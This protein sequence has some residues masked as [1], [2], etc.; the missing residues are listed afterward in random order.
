MKSSEGIVRS[1]GR[2]R[3]F[4][5]FLGF[6]DQKNVKIFG[7]DPKRVYCFFQMVSSRYSLKGVSFGSNGPFKMK[8]PYSI[9]V[10]CLDVED[11]REPHLCLCGNSLFFS[12]FFYF[13]NT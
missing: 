9:I 3:R 4:L 2:M 13:L 6:G 10:V 1:E 12:F 5:F 11:T 7:W 8:L